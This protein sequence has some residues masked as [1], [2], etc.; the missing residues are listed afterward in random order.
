MAQEALV[1]M[2]T[3]VARDGA[4]RAGRG[5]SGL[6]GQ[7]ISIHVPNVRI[8]TKADACDAVGGEE[9]LVLG[10]YLS[11]SGDIT[12]HVM[13]LFPVARA[14]ECVDLMCGQ[15][16]GTTVEPDELAQSAVGELGNIVG[17]AFVNALADDLNL[18]LHPSPPTIIHDMAIALVQSVYAEV[19]S[20]GGDVV[21]MDAVF[22]DEK[23]RTAGL[24]IVAP[25]P[26]SVERLMKV[27]A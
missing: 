12:G 17:S 3:L 4:V 25:D 24:L 19:L 11:I 21:M 23:G 8:G 7:Q 18:I 20:Q 10:A 2:L 9:N 15:A 13:L 16:P 6:M 26:T 27:A 14:L 22:E 1:Q 5:L